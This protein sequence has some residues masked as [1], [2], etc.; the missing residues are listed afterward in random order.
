M[1]VITL[2]IISRELHSYDV[3]IMILPSNQNHAACRCEYL[4]G[5]SY[6]FYNFYLKL[7]ISIMRSLQLICICSLLQ[8]GCKLLFGDKQHV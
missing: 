7:Q 8:N 2:D 5:K 3:W 6:S 4:L 1:Y